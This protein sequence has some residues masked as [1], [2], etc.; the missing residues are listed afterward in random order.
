MNTLMINNI[1][2]DVERDIQHKEYFW[3]FEY[4]LY[5]FTFQVNVMK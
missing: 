3:Y 1:F 2:T 5:M 4:I